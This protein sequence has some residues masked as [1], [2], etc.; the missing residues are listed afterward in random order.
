M[1]YMTYY[2]YISSGVYYTYILKPEEKFS[3]KNNNKLKCENCN[4]FVGTNAKSLAVHQR[5][6]KTKQP[7]KQDN[8]SEELIV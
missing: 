5:K 6:C 3:F 1:T 7:V 8:S 4:S 2:I